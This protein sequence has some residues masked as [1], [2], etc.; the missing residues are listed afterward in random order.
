MIGREVWKEMIVSKLMYGCGA[1]A[2]Y[3]RE[4]DDIEVMQNGFDR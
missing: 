1:L 3:Q 2:C 4:C